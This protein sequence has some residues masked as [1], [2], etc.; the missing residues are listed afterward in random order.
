[1]VL[2]WLRRQD[3][4]LDEQLRAYLF[5]DGDIVAVEAEAVGAPEAT[6]SPASGDG[7]LGLA[8]FAEDEVAP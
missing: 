7:S 3:P 2:E 8:I 1:M 4:V 6:S 5:K